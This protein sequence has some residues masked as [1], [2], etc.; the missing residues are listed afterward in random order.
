MRI[1]VKGNAREVAKSASQTADRMKDLSRPLRVAAAS[2][3]K[4]VDDSF[5]GQKSPGGTPWKKLKKS[6]VK[7]RRKGSNRILQD[8]SRLR[9]SWNARA[10]R[11]SLTITTNVPYA[12]FHQQGTKHLPVREM[13]PFEF[14]GG[15]WRLMTTG[16]AL[17]AWNRIRASVR[18]YIATGRL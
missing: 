11:S 2:L 7:R 9:R 8:T 5:R 13:A 6:T 4:L 10:D 1:T 18:R 14:V 12:R 15:V 3:D 17:R 16:P